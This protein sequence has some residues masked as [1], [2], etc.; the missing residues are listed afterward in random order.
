MLNNTDTDIDYFQISEYHLKKDKNMV[1]SDFFMIF[2]RNL[3]YFST[4]QGKRIL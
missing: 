3:S 1:L 4:F 2:F